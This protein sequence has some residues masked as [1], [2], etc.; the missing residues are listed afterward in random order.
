MEESR[1]P[2]RFTRLSC[3]LSREGHSIKSISEISLS[4]EDEVVARIAKTANLTSKEV[5][6]VFNLR[7]IG[8][9]VNVISDI[10]EVDLSTLHTFQLDEATSEQRK[11]MVFVLHAN[12]FS[13]EDISKSLGVT[14]E[15]VREVVLEHEVKARQAES[16]RP[17]ASSSSSS[18][19][20]SDSVARPKVQ[21]TRDIKLPRAEVEIRQPRNYSSSS[22]SSDSDIVARPKVQL[23]RDIKLPR[24]EVKAKISGY[25]S[26]SSSSE[27]RPVKVQLTRDIKPPKAVVRAPKV[28]VKAHKFG[29]KAGGSS[30]SDSY[31][32]IQNKANVDVG[33]KG[34]SSSSSSEVEVSIKQNIEFGKKAQ[35]ISSSSDSEDSSGQVKITLQ[36]KESDSSS[37]SQELPGVKVTVKDGVSF[38]SSEDEHQEK[39]HF[40]NVPPD[41]RDLTTPP[42]L[43]V[44]LSGEGHQEPHKVE[45][46]TESSWGLS[47]LLQKATDAISS[48]AE[49][50]GIVESGPPS[51]I[52]VL[53]EPEGDREAGLRISLLKSSS[54]SSSSSSSEV[55]VPLDLA[56][57][58]ADVAVALDAELNVEASAEAQ[59]QGEAEAQVQGES[60]AQGEVAA[61]A[62]V[63][64]EVPSVEI[65]FDALLNAQAQLT[66][67]IEAVADS[68]ASIALEVQPEASASSEVAAEAHGEASAE[69][70][71]EA[72]AEASVHIELAS[73]P[74]IVLPEVHIEAS[75]GGHLMFTYYEQ[76]NRAASIINIE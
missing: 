62:E 26:S 17:R 54:S 68:E 65:A 55:G 69:V 12:G 8:K 44:D 21:L 39:A 14:G 1:H 49:G 28:E 63:Q 38:S 74:P 19:S 7:G 47:G 72:P 13:D 64:V 53:D 5:R 6:V 9:T 4:S 16:K 2:E 67:V 15:L 46:A 45:Y 20:D 43:Q 36:R 42:T 61:E 50:L 30:S 76:T 3:S 35:V 58:L 41:F 32:S 56:Q 75:V 71:V 34:S 73:P 48:V 29:F 59:V 57:S 31:D 11:K 37:D 18:S 70:S 52:Y 51:G 40:V 24:A 22:S 10:F 25:S 66:E 23:T 27:E 33:V 60:E